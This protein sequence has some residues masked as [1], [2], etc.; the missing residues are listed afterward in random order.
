MV[1]VNWSGQYPALC[2]GEWSIIVDGK[3][4]SKKIPILLRKSPM[5]TYKIYQSWSFDMVF[6]EMCESYA[7][8][9]RMDKWIKAN[10]KWLRKI[11]K[12]REKQEEIYK[13]INSK[14][15]RHNSC[16]GCI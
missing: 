6:N 16:G 13:G 11:T 2:Q 10:R 14:D 7:D 12:S 3:D 15:F 4:V 9:L 5:N 1:E 8:G